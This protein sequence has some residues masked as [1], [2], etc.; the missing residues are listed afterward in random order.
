MIDVLARIPEDEG[1][2]IR[3]SHTQTVKVESGSCE[4]CQHNHP[5]HPELLKSAVAAVRGETDSF[6][7]E[8]LFL[9]EEHLKACEKGMAA[10]YAGLDVED[11]APKEGHVFM[12]SECTNYDGHGSWLAFFTSY[13]EAMGFYRRIEDKAAPWMGLYPNNG[14]QE[15]TKEQAAAIQERDRK[16]LEDQLAWEAKCQ[17]EDAER[18]KEF[19]EALDFWGDEEEYDGYEEEG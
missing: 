13:R 8:V 14:I 2:I 19:R 9:C 16:Y 15:V 17:A 18:E 5:E 10:K 3:C 7:F 11:R 1:K 4:F 6:G 12:V